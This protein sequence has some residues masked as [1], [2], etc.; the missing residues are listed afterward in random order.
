MTLSLGDAPLSIEQVLA[1]SRSGLEVQFTNSAEIRMRKSR[2]LFERRLANG[3]TIYGVN[4]GVGRNV[5]IAIDTPGMR[6]LQHNVMNHLSCGTGAPLSEDHVRAATLL[7]L[8]TF[9]K[10]TSAV[11]L[12][13]AS[14]LL[15]LLNSGIVPIVPRYGSLGASG[16]LMPSAYVARILLGQ[17]EVF[18]RGARM[19]AVE[20]LATVGLSPIE[21]APKEGIALVN[22]TTFMSGAVAL[23]WEDCRRVQQ[24]L[25]G[26]VALTVEALQATAEPFEPWVHEQKGHPGQ[27]AV[28]A[29]LRAMIKG[30]RFVRAS[31]SQDCYSLRCAPQG[32]GP[33]WEGLI[34][35]RDT[36]EREMNSANDNP[37]I[38]PETG[39]IFQ[40]GNFYGGHI[41]R[42][43]DTWKMDLSIQATW[44][45]ALFALLVDSRF[46]RGLP[47]NLAPE[48]GVNCGFQGMQLSITSLACAART[49]AGS[50]SIHTLP[51]EQY[52]QD[53]VSLGM[54]AAVTA[55]DS[56]ACVRNAVAMVLLAAAQAV[57]LRGE[58]AWL[59]EGSRKLYL[60]LRGLSSFVSCDRAMENDIAA[61]SS[62]I[63]TGSLDV[64]L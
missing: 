51:T 60:R 24:A 6:R 37:L 7:R 34:D 42:L 40:A 49:F 54:H 22:G 3:Q 2:E 32:L 63:E 29:Y 8:A 12:E 15:R 59:G 58:P 48:A 44:A 14:A 43:L 52:N 55:A 13:L 45:N 47:S 36:I 20:A 46:N 57:D 31:E 38:D 53:V 11:R 23:L 41:A 62:A 64:G 26:A 28:S 33:G 30:S 19:M 56:L 35:A 39:A 9:A 27:M 25:L 50:S 10:G 18:F 16:D 61:V 17:G 1:V 21:L 5:N 4:T